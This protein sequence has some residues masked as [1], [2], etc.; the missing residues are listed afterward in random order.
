[1]SNLPRVLIVDDSSVVRASFARHLKG[2]YEIRE[3]S[4]GESAWQSLVLDQSIAA[5]ISDLQ[6]PVLDGLGLLE[7]L[8]SCR[9]SRL[10]NIPFVLV[11]GDDSQETLEKFENL[12]VSD[13]IP[14]DV[15]ASE[16]RTRLHRLLQFLHTQQSLEESLANQTKDPKTGLFTRRYIELHAAQSLSRSIRHGSPSCLIIIGFDNYPFIVSQIGEEKAENVGAKFAK[17]V[18]DKV[19]KEDC[20]GHFSPGRFAI[21]SPGTTPEACA[22]FANRLRRAIAEAVISVNGRRIPLSM[23]A[24]IASVPVDSAYSAEHLMELAYQRMESAIAAGGN[25]TE[26]G[27]SVKPSFAAPPLRIDQALELIRA[28]RHDAVTP[29]LSDLGEQL[30]PLLR[31]V[32]Q[33]LDP[34]LSLETLEKKLAEKKLPDTPQG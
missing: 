11:S 14:K 1:M 28:Q 4:N 12:G 32:Q 5:V 16:L 31:L 30:L 7:R 8:R 33:E 6:M 21:V 22:I 19:R 9:L 17:K 20:I 13:F 10:R 23:S 3:E 29:Q 18:A 2:L 24:G 34:G 27:D 25:R 26:Y 15:R